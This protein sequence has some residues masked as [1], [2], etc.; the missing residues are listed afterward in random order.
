MPKRI[1]GTVALLVLL[2]LAGCTKAPVSNS[3]PGSNEP[4]GIASTDVV[5]ATPQEVMIARGESKDAIVP[6]K[7]RHGYHV[8]ANPPSYSYLKA[9]E[10]ELQPAA[11][12]SVE[13]ITYPDP[14]VKKFAFAE[15]PLA[16]YEGETILKA[17]LKADQSA[18][19]GKHNLSAKLR[20]Q[21]CDEKLCYPPGVLEVT[22]PVNIR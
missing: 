20:V 12:I 15:K 2:S 19:V 16:V 14:L 18:P 5:E 11:G 6:I 7:I 17:R 4:P 3:D 22:V 8:N 21:A 10:L 9:T 1:R 13:F